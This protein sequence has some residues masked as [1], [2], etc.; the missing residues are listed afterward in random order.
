ML[1]R[2]CCALA[3]AA[4]PGPAAL[5]ADTL[6]DAALA[7]DAEPAPPEREY[8][9]VHLVTGDV[10]VGV[11]ILRQGPESITLLHPSFGSLNIRCERIRAIYPE[12]RPSPTIG[13]G[14]G[15][16][17]PV[18][19]PA[20]PRT[21]ITDANP[22]AVQPAQ[23]PPQEPAAPPTITDEV[24]PSGEPGQPA[25]P[26]D[27]YPWKFTLEL[28]MSG[29]AGNTEQLNTRFAGSARRQS[30]AVITEIVTRYRLSV[31]A[32]ETTANEWFTRA[33]NDWLFP[34]EPWTIFAEGR[35]EYNE[36]RN[37]TWRLAARAGVANDFIKTDRTTLN[38]SVGLG[39]AR[40][41]GGDRNDLIPEATIS[42]RATHKFNERVSGAGRV[43]YYPD[44]TD[45]S[46]Y[47]VI[48]AAEMEVILDDSR[49]LRLKA[50]VEDR[51]DTRTGR[52][53]DRNDIDYFLTLVVSF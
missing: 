31:S 19:D 7:S 15:E 32:G 18:V 8:V 23:Q 53:R 45:L 42:M 46:S 6:A 13:A 47:G 36:F 16:L 34:N 26:P 27:P 2:L 39:V 5:A 20:S 51:Y 4:F 25:S 22:P 24:D 1:R 37:Y 49:S 28:G 52:G 33:R 3:I 29:S 40:E 48:A 14:P 17:V 50:G 38:V 43:E 9:N 12:P 10:L 30:N 44:L 11:V 35:T 21:L 41:F